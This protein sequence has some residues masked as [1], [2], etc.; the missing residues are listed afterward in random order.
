MP[1]SDGVIGRDPGR[2]D[3]ADF[4]QK[5]AK[6]AEIQTKNTEIRSKTDN[7]NSPLHRLN[8]A[9]SIRKQTIYYFKL[10]F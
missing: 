9:L 2:L 3:G 6:I 4:D 8:Y 1:A 5:R 10:I 7:I